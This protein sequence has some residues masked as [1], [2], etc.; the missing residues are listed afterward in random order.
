[1]SA[2]LEHVILDVLRDAQPNMMRARTLLAEVQLSATGTVTRADFE[3]AVRSLENKTGGAQM[4]GIG[5]EDG[6][7]YKITPEGLARLAGA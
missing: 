6:A 1:M 7:K 4:V 2:A 5:N 3:A